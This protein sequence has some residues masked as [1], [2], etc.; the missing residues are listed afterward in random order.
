MSKTSRAKSILVMFFT[1]CMALCFFLGIGAMTAG[2]EGEASAPTTAWMSGQAQPVAEGDSGIVSVEGS[3]ILANRTDILQQP[4]R[5]VTFQ[6]GVDSFSSWSGMAFLNGLEDS[7]GK[8]WENVTWPG[9]NSGIDTLP[10]II[11]QNGSAQI[12]GNTTSAVFGAPAVGVTGMTDKFSTYFV[13]VEIHIG[14]GENDDVS[15]MKVDGTQLTSEKDSV[16]ALSYIK[17]SDFPNGC[18]FGMHI[19]L[20]TGYIWLGEFNAP[21]ITNVSTKLQQTLDLNNAAPT[22]KLY[23]TVHELANRETAVFKLNGEAVDAA[24]FTVSEA[25]DGSEHCYKYTIKKTFW[26][27]HNFTKT[28]WL[29]WES[30][31]GKAAYKLTVLNEQPPK[32]VGGDHRTIQKLED[33]SYSIFYESETVYAQEDIGVY[34]GVN[35]KTVD[36]MNALTAGQDFTL[37]RDGANYTFTVKASYLTNVLSTYNGRYFQLTLGDDTLECTLYKQPEQEGWIVRSVDLVEN[38]ELSV[39]DI[40]TVGNFVR[41]NE[42]NMAP[43]VY[44]NEGLD[45]TKPIV[46]EF[47]AFGDSVEWGMLQVADSLKTMDF[48]SDQTKEMS[49]LQ[50]LFFGGRSD[51]QKYYGFVATASTN[52]N[53]DSSTMKNI[54]VEMYFGA[55]ESESYFK[56]N[57]TDCGTPTA[58]QSDFA[59]GKAYIGFFLNQRSEGEFILNSKVNAVAVTSPTDDASYKMDIAD[60]NDFEVTLVSTSGDLTLTNDKGYTLVSGTD[61]TFDAATGKLTLKKAYFEQLAFTKSGSVSVWDNVSQSGTK[62]N[63]SYSSSDMQDS[64]LVFGVL[65]ALT[66]VTI[67][68]PAEVASVDMLLGSDDNE[69]DKTMYSFGDG[70]LIIN[71]DLIAD[72]TGVTEFIA[73]S[74]SALYPVY[75]YV[76]AFENGYVKDGEGAVVTGNGAY[77]VTDKASVTLMNGFSLSEGFS[78]K[79]DFKSIPGYYQGGLNYDKAGYVCFNF[80]DPYSGYTLT[81][82]LYASF[83]KDSVSATDTALYETYYMKDSEGKTVILDTSR[84]LNVSKSENPDALGVH[85]I[86][87]GVND[88]GD[89]TITVDNARSATIS[90]DIGAFNLSACV[91]T[92]ETPASATEGEMKLGFVILAADETPD[93]NEVK[94]ETDQ[95][96]D[97]PVDSS[98]TSSSSQT[99]ENPPVSSDEGNSSGSGTTSSNEKGCGSSMSFVGVGLVALAAMLIV[100][101]KK[102][103]V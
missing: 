21:Y 94:T 52:A 58:V 10:H 28:S 15:Y 103:R 80:Y 68:F 74:G 34:S 85:I 7:S 56:I 84:A 12:H 69:I 53:Y 1:F 82:I 54:V 71:K 16:S 66:D 32:W 45:V 14:T 35:Y 73:V 38:T 11:F 78:V 65:N 62:F 83:E 2:A 50:A 96:V 22:G 99:S 40:Y 81:Y 91:L 9:I 67:D 43:R 37:T 61:Y 4:N 46:V 8:S 72:E 64:L 57:G 92:I 102:F 20:N 3:A 36:R 5:T 18:Y 30:E 39:G 90:D 86:K 48:F 98:D 101:R 97:P 100:V 70:K 24:Y 23:I 13:A 63:M 42:T 6:I 79:V 51:I 95:P 27:N 31:N 33:V 88:G 77:I 75:V 26:Q 17:V 29:T 93:Y 25:S 89:I 44:Y 76:D 60:A 41:F 59:E 87:F 47:S 55:T 19:N 49:K